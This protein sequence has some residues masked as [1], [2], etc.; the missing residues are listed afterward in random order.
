MKQTGTKMILLIV[1]L[2]MHFGKETAKE[3]FT[4]RN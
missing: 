3:E 4:G 1:N 2:N